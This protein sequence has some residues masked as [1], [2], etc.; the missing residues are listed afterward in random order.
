M[1]ETLAEIWLLIIITFSGGTMNVEIHE[2]PTMFAC[3]DAREQEVFDRDN[4][5]MPGQ[6]VDRTNNH[7]FCMRSDQVGVLEQH[8]YQA[9]FELVNYSPQFIVP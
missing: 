8:E 5:T 2:N 1:K 4:R 7:I 9:E 3:F 6:P